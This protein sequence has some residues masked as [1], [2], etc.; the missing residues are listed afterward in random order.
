MVGW[1]VLSGF[2]W[3]WRCRSPPSQGES[4]KGGVDRNRDGSGIPHLDTRGFSDAFWWP[5]G[6][7]CKACL[8]ASGIQPTLIRKFLFRAAALPPVHLP[9]DIRHQGVEFGARKMLQ[10]NILHRAKLRRLVVL[11]GNLLN[12]A[13]GCPAHV[14]RYFTPCKV[15]VQL[16][17]CT[18]DLY[19]EQIIRPFSYPENGLMLLRE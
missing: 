1:S 4:V 11:Q 2:R 15:N 5:Y 18:S 7:C 6:L 8:A 13:P 17:G 3:G 14:R 12:C 16:L 10:D 9:G 19:R